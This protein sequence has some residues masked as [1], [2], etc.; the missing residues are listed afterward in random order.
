MFDVH[1][2]IREDFSPPKLYVRSS[3]FSPRA[4]CSPG[5]ATTNLETFSPLFGCSLIFQSSLV[6]G[7]CL[8]EDGAFLLCHFHQCREILHHFSRFTA[9]LHN[10]LALCW[11]LASGGK[12]SLETNLTR[13]Q[14]FTKIF[15]VDT[16]L[17]SPWQVFKCRNSSDVCSDCEDSLGYDDPIFQLKN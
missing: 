7:F 5:R 1:R 14:L 6:E 8:S 11:L 3:Q 13:G 2:V 9:S 10:P 17:A 4:S 16:T 15:C 12:A